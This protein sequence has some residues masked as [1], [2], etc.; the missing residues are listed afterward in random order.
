MALKAFLKGYR[1]PALR[2]IARGL[3]DRAKF[4]VC[5][6]LADKMQRAWVLGLEYPLGCRTFVL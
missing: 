1:I 2:G 5:C 6:I 4:E 3:L